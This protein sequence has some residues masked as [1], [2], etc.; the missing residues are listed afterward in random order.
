MAFLSSL[1]LREYTI[2]SEWVVLAP[3][4]YQPA[5]GSR[6][7]VPR[8]FIT[9]LASIPRALQNVFSVNGLSR[10]PSVVHDYL[11]CIQDRERLQCDN[12]LVEAMRSRGIDDITC[13]TFFYAVRAGGAAHW[14]TRPKGLQ[15]SD[16]VPDNYWDLDNVK[17]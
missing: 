8:G 1:D 2:D 16:C 11:Y 13:D 4:V 15:P 12:I 3:L 9:D 10:A 14:G 6:I 5:Q 17:L 7:I